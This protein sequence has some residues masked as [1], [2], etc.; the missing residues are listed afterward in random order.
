MQSLNLIGGLLDNLGAVP[1][2][3]FKASLGP[4][5]GLSNR[6]DEESLSA[7]RALRL[8]SSFSSGFA[9]L[10]AISSSKSLGGRGGLWVR[11][12]SS[13]GVS[14]AK[15]KKHHPQTLI[16]KQMRREA[17]EI[18]EYNAG[19]RLLAEGFL[20]RALSPRKKRSKPAGDFYSRKEW[21]SARYA[22]LLRADGRC[23]CCGAGRDHGA[24]MHVDHIKPR[25]KFPELAL[26]V[27]NL[28][29]LC[30]LCNMAKSN[31]D[32]T[33]WPIRPQAGTAYTVLEEDERKVYRLLRSIARDT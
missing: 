25:S 16:S 21:A 15:P 4:E 10:T 30:N 11:L 7:F 26:D 2:P 23:A 31:I 8:S 24:V 1:R 27:M 19:R 12:P 3:A 32:M 6:M 17:Q 29:V 28:Q 33:A 22:A 13:F 5:W 20:A 18:T 9:E 14:M